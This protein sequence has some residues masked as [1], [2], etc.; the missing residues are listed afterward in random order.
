M[1]SLLARKPLVRL[2]GKEYK[3]KKSPRGL[4]FY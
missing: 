3:I 1:N 4:L 2:I